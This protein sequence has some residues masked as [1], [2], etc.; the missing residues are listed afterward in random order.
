MFGGFGSNGAGEKDFC[1]FRTE[2][3]ATAQ[4]NRIPVQNH[5]LKLFSLCRFLAFRHR[6]NQSSSRSPSSFKTLFFTLPPQDRAAL[7]AVP[8][9]TFRSVPSRS[10]VAL[11]RLSEAGLCPKRCW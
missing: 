3:I 9:L 6:G 7:A 10:L 1:V 2:L 4:H 5:L 8:P 11:L